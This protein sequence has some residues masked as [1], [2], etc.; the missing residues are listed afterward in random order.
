MS[1]SI[2]DLDTPVWGAAAIAEI[3]RKTETQTNY[4]LIKRRI[5]ATKVGRLWVTTRRRLR[6]QFGGA[7][8]AAPRHGAEARAWMHRHHAATPAAAG[9]GD[10]RQGC[11]LRG[12]DIER[13]T[14]SDSATQLDCDLLGGAAF[15]PHVLQVRFGVAP[16]LAPVLAALA[17]L[18]ERQP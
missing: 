16:H 11:R 18:G 3:I 4:L 9:S 17:G 8:S 2:D 5:D 14:I 1:A 15:A 7:A 12:H 13:S 6:N 10:R